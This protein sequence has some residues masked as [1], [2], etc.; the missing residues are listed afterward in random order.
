[1]TDA[2]LAAALLTLR[3]ALG[4]VFVAHGAKHFRN[5][6]KTI[7]WTASIGFRRPAIQWFFMTFAEIGIGAALLVGVVTP[8]AASGLVAMMVV[9]FWT[10]HRHAGFF[11]TARPDE[12][13]EYV[14]TLLAASLA[15]ALLGPGEWSIDDAIGLAENL[16]GYVGLGLVLAGAAAGAGQ[17]ATF[18]RPQN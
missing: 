8:V 16:D 13:W 3:S 15:L 18:F 11:V 9:A 10:V 6:A 2:T 1:M 17:V 7:A 14:A 4:V 12:G 5:R